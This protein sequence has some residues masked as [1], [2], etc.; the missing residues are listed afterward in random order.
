MDIIKHTLEKQLNELRQEISQL[1]K[2]H[3]EILTKST[4]DLV[5]KLDESFKEFDINVTTTNIT[6]NLGGGW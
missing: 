2:Q 6:F 5:D 4:H 3:D 1:E